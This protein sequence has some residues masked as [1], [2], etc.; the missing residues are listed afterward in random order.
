MEVAEFFLPASVCLSVMNSYFAAAIQRNTLTLSGCVR[1]V[2]N[3]VG[4]ILRSIRAELDHVDF[5]SGSRVHDP[6]SANTYPS[7]DHDD[8]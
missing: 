8:L 6:A 1:N 5:H 7:P 3:V 4:K 2:L